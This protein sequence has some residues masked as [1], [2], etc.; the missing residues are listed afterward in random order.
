MARPPSPSLGERER[1]GYTCEPPHST[2]MLPCVAFFSSPWRWSGQTPG[3]H[4]D[5]NRGTSRKSH[6]RKCVRPTRRKGD[7][8]PAAA[9]PIAPRYAPAPKVADLVPTQQT[10]RR[11]PLLLPPQ[12]RRALIH[13]AARLRGSLVGRRHQTV[14]RPC[15]RVD[16]EHP[17]LG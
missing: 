4:A 7:S 11:Q 12:G 8:S 13:A 14:P 6:L 1:T 16:A 10:P 3:F 17:P 2:S 5:G 15:V 9:R